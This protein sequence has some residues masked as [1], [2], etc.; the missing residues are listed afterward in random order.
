[1]NRLLTAED[2]AELLNTTREAVYARC[3]RG[4]LPHIRTGPRQIRFDPV[5]LGRWLAHRT[6]ISSEQALRNVETMAGSSP[7]PPHRLAAERRG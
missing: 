7:Q 3:A 6:R 5:E 2:V 1:M 4:L